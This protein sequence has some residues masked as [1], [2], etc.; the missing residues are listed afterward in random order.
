MQPVTFS[1]N[2]VNRMILP[3]W[4]RKRAENQPGLLG[5]LSIM[6]PAF[7]P[8]IAGDRHQHTVN[9]VFFQISFKSID[10]FRGLCGSLSRGGAP[11]RHGSVSLL[12]V[13][14]SSL[15]SL[16]CQIRQVV[17]CDKAPLQCKI[18]FCR[19]ATTCHI[20]LFVGIGVVFFSFFLFFLPQKQ[21]LSDVIVRFCQRFE[22]TVIIQVEMTVFQTEAVVAPF[23]PTK[24]VS[25]FLPQKVNNGEKLYFTE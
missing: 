6:H 9:L 7:C 25:L 19:Q 16:F 21:V 11:Y 20:F 8:V 23:F 22:N 14:L 10:I 17:H 5:D 1:Q 15:H 13:F 18:K 2:M 12:H 24:P 3:F 4:R